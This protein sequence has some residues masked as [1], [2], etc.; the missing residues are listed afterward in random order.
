M[1]SISLNCETWDIDALRYMKPKVNDMGGK[2]ISLIST[3]TNRSLHLAT[4]LLMT[5]GIS[6]FVN[7]KG[8][9][10][11]KYAMSLN[12]PLSD[13]ETPETNAFLKK[14]KAFEEKIIDDA[15]ANSEEWFGEPR[16]REIAKHSFF[17]IIKYQKDKETKKLDHS[18]PP[19]IKVKVP[20][21]QDKW[22][23]EIYNDKDDAELLFPNDNGSTPLDFV[24]KRSDVMCLIQCGGVWVGGKGW[25]LTWKLSQAVVKPPVN[26]SVFGMCHLKL[27][28]KDHDSMNREQA[29]H[30]EVADEVVETQQ[31]VD[32]DDE[33]EEETVEVVIPA[34]PEPVK[35]VAPGAPKKKIIRK[36]PVV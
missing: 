34:T 29:A 7:D 28:S 18:K 16:S 35:K 36:K 10:D 5:W 26:T 6:D 1:S 22:A 15:V 13:Y 11:G 17:P 30:I 19:S 33:E 14:V 9:S 25:G 24:P 27:S 2:N 20:K 23:V 21:Y 12:F 3:Q 8:E 31:V 4:P 32:T